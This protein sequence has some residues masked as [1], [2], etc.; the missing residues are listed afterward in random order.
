[1]KTKLIVT[2]IV[3]VLSIALYS[4]KNIGEKESSTIALVKTV[5]GK[6]E[7]EGFL[8]NYGDGSMELKQFE[9]KRSSNENHIQQLSAMATIMNDMHAK[10][11]RYV[12]HGSHMV[13]DLGAVSSYMVFEKK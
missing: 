5:F 13:N 2:A 10:G 12:G 7:S 6:A 1:M 11:Y 8:I 4:F 3:A 9:L